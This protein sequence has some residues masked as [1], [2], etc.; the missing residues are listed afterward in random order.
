MSMLS[1]YSVVSAS[2]L[3]SKRSEYCLP[4]SVAKISLTLYFPCVRNATG[5]ASEE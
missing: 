1:I 4:S 5:T 2:S 3:T